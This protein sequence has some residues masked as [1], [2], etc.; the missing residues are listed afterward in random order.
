[1]ENW[2]LK[3]L[4]EMRNEVR[5]RLQNKLC[6]VREKEIKERKNEKAVP[7]HKLDKKVVHNYSSKHL[8]E[9][10]L[11]VLSLGLKFGIAIAPK[12]FPLVEYEAATEVLCQKLEEWVMI[13]Q[14]KRQVI[15]CPA[16]KGKAVVVEDRETFLGKM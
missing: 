12:K 2:G 9:E 6:F 4:E 7:K 5:S 8:T 11:E 1:M 10:Q 14:W 15:I 13:N 16:D 3:S